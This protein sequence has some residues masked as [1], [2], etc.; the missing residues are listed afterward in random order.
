MDTYFG[1]L[2]VDGISPVHVVHSP[3]SNRSVL[4]VSQ[5]AVGVSIDL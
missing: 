4:K 1:I 5:L 2:Q 3:A